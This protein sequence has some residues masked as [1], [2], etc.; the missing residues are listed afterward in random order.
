[1]IAGWPAG[2]V[3]LSQGRPAVVLVVV[4]HRLRA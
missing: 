4:G 1:V 2:P 3:R